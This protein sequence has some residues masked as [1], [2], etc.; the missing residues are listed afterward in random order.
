[1]SPNP[2]QLLTADASLHPEHQTIPPCITG[3]FIP[4]NLQILFSDMIADFACKDRH[5]DLGKFS[6]NLGVLIP[7]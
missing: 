5:Y 3:Y 6:S 4:N 1:M 2:P 7:K